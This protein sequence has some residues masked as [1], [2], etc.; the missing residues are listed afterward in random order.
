M[1]RIYSIHRYIGENILPR[2]NDIN[3]RLGCGW[4]SYEEVKQRYD[5]QDRSNRGPKATTSHGML[6]AAVQTMPLHSNQT[7]NKAKEF[8]VLNYLT[9]GGGTT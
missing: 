7:A 3:T 2:E 1:N 4:T 9:L 5:A 6:I 8:S